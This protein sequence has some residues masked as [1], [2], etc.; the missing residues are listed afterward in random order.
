MAVITGKDIA[1]R[2]CEIM[3][4]SADTVVSININ[5]SADEILVATVSKQVHDK[6]AD[7]I[8]QLLSEYSLIEK[9][10]N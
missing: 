8:V 3:G 5:I 2:L 7:E 9:E 10:A 6:E 4:L 1:V